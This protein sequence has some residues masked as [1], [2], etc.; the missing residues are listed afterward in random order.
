MDYAREILL[1]LTKNI[2]AARPRRMM[3]GT[4]YK[5]SSRRCDYARAILFHLT[6]NLLAARPAQNY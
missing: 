6:K 3:R 4:L 5:I 2:L 1:H